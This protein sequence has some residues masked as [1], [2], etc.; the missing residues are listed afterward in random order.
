MLTAGIAALATAIGAING[1]FKIGIDSELIEF[2]GGSLTCASIFGAMAHAAWL[3]LS[4]SQMFKRMLFI[5]FS[6]LIGAIMGVAASVILIVV[7][8]VIA[9]LYIFSYILSAS[10]SSD[11]STSSSSSNYSYNNDNE[12]ELDVEGEMFTRKAKDIGFGKYRDNQGDVW[13]KDYNGT[14]IKK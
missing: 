8:A 3:S 11:S 5:F 14:F 9:A 6:C 12:I 2:V 10:T 4:T 13:E 1:M 7:L